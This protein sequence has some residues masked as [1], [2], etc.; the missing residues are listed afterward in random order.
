V[1]DDPKQ[2]DLRQA[3]TIAIVVFLVIDLFLFVTDTLGRL[4]KDQTFHVDT[5]IFGFA[6]G[7]TLTL[8]GFA[9]FERLTGGIKGDEE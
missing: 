2:S 9:G 8:L 5:L 3:R 4:F 7:A 6:I 1:E